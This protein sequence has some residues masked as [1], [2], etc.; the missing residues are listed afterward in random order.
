VIKSVKRNFDLQRIPIQ[1]WFVIPIQILR[2]TFIIIFNDKINWKYPPNKPSKYSSTKNKIIKRNFWNFKIWTQK[3]Q[4][5]KGHNISQNKK[6]GN[7]QPFT[8]PN[9]FTQFDKPRILVNEFLHLPNDDV[10]NSFCNF[11]RDSPYWKN[12][13]DR[14]CSKNLVVLLFQTTLS[15]FL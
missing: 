13:A 14:I 1:N 12:P 6:N 9:I 15:I 2:I 10:L 4:T 8:I 3:H 11:H 7:D 5:K